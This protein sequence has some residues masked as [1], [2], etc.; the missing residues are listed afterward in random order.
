MIVYRCSW[1]LR[2]SGDVNFS[3]IRKVFFGTTDGFSRKSKVQSP[4]MELR[5]VVLVGDLD[6][7][8]SILIPHFCCT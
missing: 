6:I 1:I 4:D 7:L 3:W 8:M 2:D 5:G